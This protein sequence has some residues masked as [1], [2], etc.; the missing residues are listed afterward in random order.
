MAA[1]DHLNLQLFHGT[2]A[3]LAGKRKITP[4][5]QGSDSGGFEGQ[6]VAFAADSAEGAAEHGANVYEVHP[7]EHTQEYFGGTYY[8]EKG[9]KI[10]RVGPSAGS[11]PV[12]NS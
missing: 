3:D 6:K 5:L 8:S 4:T 7:D 12:D 11:G 9:F 2:S 1:S 10:K